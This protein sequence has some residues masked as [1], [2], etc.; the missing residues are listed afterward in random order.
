VLPER[1]IDT[2]KML[3]MDDEAIVR[4]SCRSILSEEL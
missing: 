4:E 2:R 3:V 1:N